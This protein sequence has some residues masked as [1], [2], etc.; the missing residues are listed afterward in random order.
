VAATGEL[1]AGPTSQGQRA[2]LMSKDASRVFF[3]TDES[4]VP[5]DGNG[6]GDVY[7]WD[8]GDVG[9][10]SPGVGAI[11]S[12][13]IAATPDGATVFFKTAD[14]LVP[15]DRDGGDYDFYAARIGGG[16]PEP[17]VSGEPCPCRGAGSPDRP[18]DGGDAAS[19]TSRGGRIDLA[20]LSVAARRSISRSGWIELLA[21]APSAGRLTARARARLG[22][23]TRTIASTAVTV[24]VPGPVWLRMRLSRAAR[25]R[26]TRGRGMTVSV[27]L[28]LSGHPEAA[29]TAR[30]PLPGR[31]R[32]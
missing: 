11:A 1:F 27:R 24:T 19:A 20:P 7:E 29:S 2:W 30:F 32:G 23:R 17:P 12:T 3:T 13:L 4:L 14:T 15:R 22:K 25:G 8:H 28:A 18:V 10:I 31:P 26:L 5:Q 21:E 9:L 16:F 6:A